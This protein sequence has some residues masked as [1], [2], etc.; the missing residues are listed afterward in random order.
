MPQADSKSLTSQEAAFSTCHVSPEPDNLSVT[1]MG[2]RIEYAGA[3]KNH[4]GAC[5]GPG[6]NGPA[7]V[8][9]LEGRCSHPFGERE[10]SH[11]PIRQACAPEP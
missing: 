10:K 8:F 2:I 6:A 11:T 4:A 9:T 1:E 7:A 3:D 5:K